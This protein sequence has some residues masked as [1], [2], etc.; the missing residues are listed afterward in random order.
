MPTKPWLVACTIMETQN[1]IKQLIN[2]QTA[3][4]C[5]MRPESL[6]LQWWPQMLMTTLIQSPTTQVYEKRSSANT[7][8]QETVTDRRGVS[9]KNRRSSPST[10][11]VYSVGNYS[12][13]CT[14]PVQA[15]QPDEPDKR[16]RTPSR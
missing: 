14:R 3:F 9:V 13:G 4:L 7:R 10:P 2:L 15:D 11:L 5:L 1:P 12:H 8:D 6:R 16:T